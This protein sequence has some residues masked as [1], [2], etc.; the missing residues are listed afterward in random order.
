MVP[1]DDDIF[2]KTY[3]LAEFARTIRFGV[4]KVADVVG[5]LISRITILLD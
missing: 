5:F 2:D 3:V 4:R 1:I